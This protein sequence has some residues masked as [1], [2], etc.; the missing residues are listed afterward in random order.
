MWSKTRAAK[1]SGATA[2]ELR[3][4]AF[5]SIIFIITSALALALL[6]HTKQTPVASIKGTEFKLEVAK[7][8]AERGKGLSG[9]PSLGANNGML[10]VFE[11]PGNF[12]F[13]MKGMRF[14]LDIL[15]FD[16]HRHL[17][18]LEK[19][20][21]PGTYPKSFC[22]NDSAKYVLEVNAGTSEYLK[23]Q[24]GDVIKLMLD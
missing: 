14:P 13:W 16:S 22:P 11:E 9:K 20:L 3:K 19:N 18:H 2:S 12:C 5:L 15:W 17:V 24:K 10:F 7:T 6:I 4:K 23:L 1:E 21:S 8:E